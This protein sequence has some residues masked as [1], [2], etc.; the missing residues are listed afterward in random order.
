[1]PFRWVNAQLANSYVRGFAFVCPLLIHAFSQYMG[2][3]FH[4]HFGATGVLSLVVIMGHWRSRLYV[5][6]DELSDTELKQAL[7]DIE[8]AN[9]K[10]VKRS[11]AAVSSPSFDEWG[12]DEETVRTMKPPPTSP[13]QVGK[14]EKEK[15]Q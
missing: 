5:K 3:P 7:L 12:E 8:D 9:A 13:P 1:M 14:D 10:D 11:L 2:I 4:V 6:G 15:H